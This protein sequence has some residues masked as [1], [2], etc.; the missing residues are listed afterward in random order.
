[1]SA[2]YRFPDDIDS[3]AAGEGGAKTRVP[4]LHV[5]SQDGETHTARSNEDK[6]QI[7]ADSFFPPLPANTSVPQDY[8]YPKPVA[9]KLKFT[10]E[11]I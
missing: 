10:R 4:T 2:P 11:Q 1:M 3:P 8:R 5:E 7:I 6:A 9:Y